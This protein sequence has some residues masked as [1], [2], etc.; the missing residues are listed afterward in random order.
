M[1]QQNKLKAIFPRIVN[2]QFTRPTWVSQASC[3]LLEGMLQPDL[4]RRFSLADVLAHP[5]FTEGA[6]H[7]HPCS[8]ST[9]S[10]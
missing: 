8:G 2:A 10:Q 6:P 1:T 4:K 7:T 9:Q 3:E 5:W